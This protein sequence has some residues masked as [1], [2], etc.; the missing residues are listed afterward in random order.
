MSCRRIAYVFLS[1]LYML[2][3][4]STAFAVSDAERQF[5]LMYFKEEE[6]EVISATRRLKS[7]SRVA[8]NVEVVTAEDIELMNAHTVSE[9]LT[10]VTGVQVH[11]TGGPGNG[12]IALIQGSDPRHVAFF[13]DGVPMVTADN[14]TN[15]GLI[16]IQ[17][18]QKIEVIKGPAS[19]AWGSSLGGIVNIVTRELKSHDGLG[20]TAYASYGERNTVD[21]RADV[22][23]KKG[24]LGLYLFAGTLDSDGLVRSFGLWSNNLYGKVGVDLSEKSDLLFSM[25]YHRDNRGDGDD[26]PFA[27]TYYGFQAEDL[28][29]QVTFNST[30]NSSLRFNLSVWARW[31]QEELYLGTLGVGRF[32]DESVFSTNYGTNA[33]VTW[34][35]GGHSMVAGA[36]FEK[37]RIKG[38]AYSEDGEL[39]KYAFYANDTISI[40]SF[41]L[42]PGIRYDNYSVGGDV[43]SPS[44]G[45]TYLVSKKL[46]LRASV[47]RGFSSPPVGLLTV[48]SVF[49]EFRKNPDL[50]PEKVWSYQ[51]GAEADF[52]EMLWLKFM[53]FRHDIRDVINTGAPIDE[54]PFT[55]TAVNEGKQRREGFEI[56]FRTRPVYHFSL[57]GGA[58][59]IHAEDR[60][61]NKEIEGIPEYTYDVGMK[62]DDQKS[63]KALLKG[64]YIWWN[65]E[66]FAG[67][68]YSSM[69]FDLNAIKSFQI[70]K[71]VK[72]DLF[73]TAHNI[74]NAN[75]YMVSIY[76]NPDRWVEGGLRVAF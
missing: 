8:E 21:A 43:V 15:A 18:I 12:A 66:S 30:L 3:S 51:A 33:R 70:K 55:Q 58:A 64:H 46:L 61:T 35:K 56:E 63:F 37:D 27:D 73:V 25:Y 17:M 40:G 50:E 57:F 5:L 7:I 41:S 39:R 42:T 26:L 22:S 45:A 76:V 47:S 19:A 10:T 23:A 38:D 31:L 72:L 24:D 48:E 65:R 59:F 4:T 49:H 1:L 74:F 62:Y 32:Y 20:G 69:V 52:L 60:E 13:I 68:Q 11:Q 34:E 6:L 16:P 36:E 71:D 44:L 2:F 67:A 14:I 28:F 54:P 29:G 53:V 75:Q 9:V